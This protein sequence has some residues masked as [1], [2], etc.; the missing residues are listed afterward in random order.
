MDN[1]GYGNSPGGHKVQ[2]VGCSVKDCKYHSGD[3][4]CIAEHIKVQNESAQRKAETYC[5]TFT[6]R[7]SGSSM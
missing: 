2:N 4:V 3:D 1:H 5:G 7:G 6:Q